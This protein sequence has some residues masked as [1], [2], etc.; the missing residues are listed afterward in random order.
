MQKLILW[1]GQT[2]QAPG[3]KLGDRVRDFGD[4]VD[5]AREQSACRVGAN[6][7]GELDGLARRTLVEAEN[8]VDSFRKERPGRRDRASQIIQSLDPVSG[9]LPPSR[10]DALVR[11]WQGFEDYFTNV[12]HHADPGSTEEFETKARNCFR[13]LQERLRPPT[14]ETQAHLDT[15][16][17]E[18]EEGA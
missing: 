1:G 5:L 13:F 11:E 15:L 17:R 14:V 8:L 10:G 16:I 18:A 9:S 7:E 2:I 3:Q 6:W 4:V 12:S